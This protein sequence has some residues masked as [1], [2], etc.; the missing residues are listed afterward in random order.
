MNTRTSIRSEVA[1]RLSRLKRRTLRCSPLP[2]ELRFFG[3]KVHELLRHEKR[4]ERCCF[5]CCGDILNIS[6]DLDERC[7]FKDDSNDSDEGIK[8]LLSRL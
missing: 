4:E 2:A 6:V 1:A 5:C 7:S 8:A 3:N